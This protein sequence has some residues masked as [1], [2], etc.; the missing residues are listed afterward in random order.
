MEK[1]RSAKEKQAAFKA[2]MIYILMELHSRSTWRYNP[3]MRY[4]LMTNFMSV[5]WFHNHFVKNKVFH[6]RFL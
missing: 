6:W 4:T 3:L 2:F 1:M 5:S